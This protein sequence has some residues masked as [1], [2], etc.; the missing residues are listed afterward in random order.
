[1]QYNLE[2]HA[3]CTRGL[4]VR[5]SLGLNK[6][7][8]HFCLSSDDHP[9]LGLGAELCKGSNGLDTVQR[10]EVAV[11]MERKIV[12]RRRKLLDTENTGNAV[13]FCV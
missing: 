2:L 6:T 3:L 7:S 12:G 5:S 1:M 13:M 9:R 4:R 10:R 8:S 11:R